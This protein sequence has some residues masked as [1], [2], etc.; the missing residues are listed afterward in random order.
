LQWRDEREKEMK[1]EMISKLFDRNHP[2]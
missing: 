2:F 1:C